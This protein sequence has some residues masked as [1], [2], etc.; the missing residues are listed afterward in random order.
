[1][2]KSRQ[3]FICEA[4]GYETFKWMGKCPRCAAWD[5]IREIRLE[6]EP[7]ERPDRK[8]PVTLGD[9]EVEEE[10]LLKHLTDSTGKLEDILAVEKELSR[11]RTEV[12]QMQGQMRVLQDLTVSPVRERTKRF[13]Q[14]YPGDVVM[15]IVLVPEC[16][17]D[18]PSQVEAHRLV[19]LM[20][21]D[22]DK[23][24]A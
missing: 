22:G 19:D 20:P 8:S 12:E 9:G 13:V 1:M 7:E 11:V 23:F 6:P 17:P 2:A 21:F 5:S 24:I 15:L 10:R 18:G 4:C 14:V 3:T 16:A